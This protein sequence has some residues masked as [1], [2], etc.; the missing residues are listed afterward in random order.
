VFPRYLHVIVI[1]TVCVLA[2]GRELAELIL[3][4]L[5]KVVGSLP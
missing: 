4:A 1:V 3:P 5:G 2:L